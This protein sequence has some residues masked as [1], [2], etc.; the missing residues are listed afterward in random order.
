MIETMYLDK[1]N[2]DQYKVTIHNSTIK[3]WKEVDFELYKTYSDDSLMTGYVYFVRNKTNHE[4][5]L[6][7]NQFWKDN[8]IAISIENPVLSPNQVTKV[9]TIGAN[10][11]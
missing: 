3:L 11:E 2:E 6:T 1:S 7:E 4:I 5:T 9:F 8:T 10:D